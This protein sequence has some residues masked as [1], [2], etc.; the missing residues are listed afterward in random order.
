MVLENQ[1]SDGVSTAAIIPFHI[2]LP[3][4]G[5]EWWYLGPEVL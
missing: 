3:V 2:F 1:M 5:V 4:D